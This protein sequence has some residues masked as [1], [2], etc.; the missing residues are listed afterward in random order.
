MASLN[1]HETRIT[2]AETELGKRVPTTWLQSLSTNTSASAFGAGISA[3]YLSSSSP[4]KP[5][6]SDHALFTLAYS[7]I[8]YYQFAGDWRTDN[9]YVRGSNSSETNPRSWRKVWLNGDKITGA[10]WNDYAEYFPKGEET[11]AGDIIALDINSNKEQYVKADCNSKRVVGVHSDSYGHILG[12][13][14]VEYS[15][16]FFEENNKKYIPIGLAGRVYVKVKGKVNIG[17]YIVPSDEK[18]IGR[19]LN[20]DTEPLKNIVGYVVE[21][22]NRT[23]LRRVKIFITGGGG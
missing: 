9:L 22:D 14:D 1:N 17:D 19:V 8:W 20:E 6:G 16:D 18:G 15:K 4:D 3:R 23:D 2:N 21:A 7:N 13:D 11:N 12:G 5:A 10:V